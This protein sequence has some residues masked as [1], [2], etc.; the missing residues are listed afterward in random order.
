MKYI[1]TI[2]LLGGFSGLSAQVEIDQAI[3]LTGTTGNR[4]IRNLEVPVNGTDAVNKDY[5]D[6]AVS[7]SGG[8]SP[9]WYKMQHF[10]SG[11]TFTVPAGV[12]LIKVQVLGGG[13]GG[14]TGG[15]ASGRVQGGGGGGGGY[16]EGIFE[17]TS[18]DSY[19]VVVGSGGTGASSGGDN[20]GQPGTASSLSGPGI[21]ISATGGDGGFCGRCSPYGAGGMGG[22]GSGGQ[23]NTTHGSGGAGGNGSSIA[24]Q[25]GGNG[26]GTGGGNA[27]GGGGG[28]VGGGYGGSHDPN[29]ALAGPAGHARPNSGAGGGGGAFDRG[30]GGNGAA[31]RVS[32]FW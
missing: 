6:N 21:N 31:G 12:T 5:V 17:V 20:S 14:G 13:G 16:A 7:A 3:E 23:I 4:A 30:A 9:M 15:F 29:F 27:G 24:G 25:Q 18:G 11:G 8:S 10:T 32:V 19:T 22:W 26:G 28:G 1:F 2:A